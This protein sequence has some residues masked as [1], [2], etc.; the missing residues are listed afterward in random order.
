V[1]LPGIVRFNSALPITTALLVAVLV[2]YWRAP[3]LKTRP[4]T[5][6]SL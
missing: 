2:W 4:T 5:E 3:R 6:A 1:L